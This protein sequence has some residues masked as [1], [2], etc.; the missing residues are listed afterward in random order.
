MLSQLCPVPMITKSLFGTIIFNLPRASPDPIFNAK[1]LFAASKNPN[2]INGTVGLYT[3]PTPDI[4]SNF[5]TSPII[6]YLLNDSE[7]QAEVGKST[8]TYLPITGD[9]EYIELME[10]RFMPSNIPKTD[11]LS[12]QTLS[13]T[14]G[15]YLANSIIRQL[16][17]RPI[18]LPEQTWA[19]HTN[20]FT[21]YKNYTYLDNYD[22]LRN[23]DI[24]VAQ[25]VSIN[26]M[27]RYILMPFTDIMYSKPNYP[28]INDNPYLNYNIDCGGQ[29]NSKYNMRHDYH[30]E[31]SVTDK[32]IPVLFH[33]C[34]HN[35][36][37][38]DISAEQWGKVFD[39][40]LSIKTRSGKFQYLPVFDT[41]YAGFASGEVSHDVAPLKIAADKGI[42][43]MTVF[44]CSKNFGLYGARTGMLS[45]HLPNMS[46]Y[47]RTNLTATVSKI[48]RAQYSNPPAFG[49]SVVKYILRNS[50]ISN[51]WENML[52]EVVKDIK[53]KREFIADN[54]VNDRLKYVKDG[55]GMFSLLDIT[56]KQIS[57]LK[58]K[59]GIFTVGNRISYCGIQN[60]QLKYLCDT[61]NKVIAN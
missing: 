16:T 52:S 26:D 22:N 54:V 47:D 8:A 40:M 7:F 58:E 14:G 44:S 59:Y 2:K 53:Y 39:A 18:I 28:Y 6:K 51:E 27:I 31:S 4:W 37:G 19:N 61:L 12:F 20:I 11:L 56:S 33:T 17:D 21:N 30:D 55:K 50:T 43:F 41:A 42:P 45:F 34:A 36:T 57:I 38:I 1:K 60:S 24:P 3:S 23:G 32:L 13:G 15:L 25:R 49:S 5:P 46:E 10:R 29:Y 48:I 35:P 9:P